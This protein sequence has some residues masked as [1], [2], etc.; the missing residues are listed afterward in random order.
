MPDKNATNE[1][2]LVKAIEGLPVG[3]LISD[4][5][6]T[7]LETN[8]V[9]DDIFGYEPGEL[10]G[11]PLSIL[12]QESVRKVHDELIRMYFEKPVNK[13]M[14]RGR[15]L[16]GLH[17]TGK[18]IYLN[19]GLSVRR[20]GENIRAMASVLDVTG[21]LEAE[22][23]IDRQKRLLEEIRELLLHHLQDPDSGDVYY[24]ML[25][26]FLDH[27]CS[28]LGFI[29]ELAEDGSS[30]VVRAI[31]DISWDDWS[32][33][34]FRNTDDGKSTFDRLDSLYGQVIQSGQP[35]IANEGSADPRSA[36]IIPPGH[37]PIHRFLGIPLIYHGKTIAIAAAANSE[38]EYT[39]EEVQSLQVLT[40]AMASIV[41]GRRDRNRRNHAIENLEKQERRFRSLVENARDLIGVFDLNKHIVY[42]TPAQRALLGFTH[43]DL[44][45][46]DATEFIHPDDRPRMER[47][48]EQLVAGQPV[49]PEI[50]YRY[51]H[52]DGSYRILEGTFRL[53]RDISDEPLIVVNAKDVTELEY[54][55][56]SLLRTVAN[57][58]SESAAKNRFMAKLSHEIRTPLNAILG[59][60]DLLLR[61]KLD[62]DHEQLL[63]VI[64]ASGDTL[65]RLLNDLLEATQLETE[66]LSLRMEPL[67]IRD[68][69]EHTLLAYQYDAQR[70][71]IKFDFQICENLPSRAIG[72]AGRIKQIL[73]NLVSNAIKYSPGGHIRV[74]VSRISEN[75]EGNLRFRV[76]VSDT[77][78]G[79]PESE[80]KSIFG[81][82]SRLKRTGDDVI[83]GVGLGLYIVHQLTERMEGTIRVVSPSAEFREIHPDSVGSDFIVELELQECETDSNEVRQ[84]LPEKLAFEHSL[85]VLVAEDN[86]SNQ[87]LMERMLR[88][89]NCTV[90][91][92]PDGDTACRMAAAEEYDM[93][94]LDIN[95]P[96]L[97]G[98]EAA[99]IIRAA[100]GQVPI[101]ALSAAA[102]NPGEEK[103]RASGMT[104]YLTKPVWQQNL[105][106][107]LR[108]LT[109]RR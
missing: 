109:G 33:S 65:M 67:S 73:T 38:Q 70:H 6:G 8:S 98:F 18:K 91:I 35:I 101:V 27:T 46:M 32:R 20:E 95:M 39:E 50:R 16:P 45:G 52:Q 1:A 36:G 10:A 90:T 17:R 75:R 84:S 63:Q 42:S 71:N 37:L 19:I 102:E 85:R 26:T 23:E 107:V 25:S 72:D 74:L 48:V 59:L 92:V 2:G 56:T 68:V 80:Q 41:A 53:D 9:L 7:I 5:K 34:W 21:R 66:E 29:G 51:R 58:Q 43:Q 11:K 94:I 15:V 106:Q 89:M 104:L 99:R 28:P 54:Y 79:I 81:I 64:H 78:P 57:L 44:E 86:P 87:I 60:T 30:L 24:R 103:L 61:E 88:D 62:R 12:L 47:L 3:V 55:Q 83:P 22:K 13:L 96:G 93:I 4:E 100:N 69:L 76:V 31:T 49:P 40:E 77:G 14:D 97:N 108:E 105:F 82:F